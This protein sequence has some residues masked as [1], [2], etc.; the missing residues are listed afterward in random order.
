MSA[1]SL[2]PA[3]DTDESVARRIFRA[4]SDPGLTEGYKGDDRTLTQWQT[5]AVM[6]V[7]ATPPSRS[8]EEVEPNFVA[9]PVWPS[10][11]PDEDYWSA[12]IQ[13]IGGHDQAAVVHA[14]DEAEARRRQ[15]LVLAALN[16]TATLP[17]GISRSGEE[18]ERL[19]MQ[20]RRVRNFSNPEDVFEAVP[21]S[22]FDAE[23]S[24]PP[25]TDADGFTDHERERADAWT[26]GYRNAV[27]NL[28]S[29]EREAAL[30]E[31]RAASEAATQGEWRYMVGQID[32][33][34]ANVGDEDRWGRRRVADVSIANKSSAERDANA[35]LIVGAVNYVRQC[36]AA[37]PRTAAV[38]ADGVKRVREAIHRR[39][40]DGDDAYSRAFNNG[41]RAAETAALAALQPPAKGADGARVIVRFRE[42]RPPYV[43]FD[44]PI[45]GDP[46][47]LLD[48]AHRVLGLELAGS[49]EVLGGGQ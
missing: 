10:D 5:D 16:G 18:V 14:G 27:E 24:T 33:P 36:L 8:G 4:I 40:R 45:E 49:D 31:L 44:P 17:S 30:E 9:G 26:R 22:A 37:N 42:G 29:T 2:P 6:R 1:P 11:D 38:E 13:V 32:A 35:A 12:E 23:Q 47:P 46:K 25:S 41:L 48:E 3:A 21:L 43:D 15:T 7:L 19:R 28:A 20:A 34:G 39:L